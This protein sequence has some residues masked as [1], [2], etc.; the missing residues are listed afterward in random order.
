MI[1]RDGRVQYLHRVVMED[2]LGRP[3]WPDENV[4]HI[5]GDRAD[6]RLENLELW[7]RSQ[8][9]G[10]RLTDKVEWATELLRRH[11]PE[12]LMRRLRPT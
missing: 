3:L 5:N 7:S 9:S 4:H 2:H 10:Q 12:R 6:N 8:P 1:R 11:A